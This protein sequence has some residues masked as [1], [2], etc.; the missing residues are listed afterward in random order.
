LRVLLRVLSDEERRATRSMVAEGLAGARPGRAL[1]FLA[2]S[3]RDFVYVWV[4]GIDV[5]V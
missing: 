3:D 5:N 1:F 4:D 2:P